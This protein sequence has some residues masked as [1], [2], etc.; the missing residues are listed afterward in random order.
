MN[1]LLLF[2]Y[3]DVFDNWHASH[4]NTKYIFN[5]LNKI[6]EKGIIEPITKN[7]IP[8]T[9][10]II[11]EDNLRESILANG[12]SSRNRG[13]LLVLEKLTINR[14][15][16]STK[17]LLA[18]G[19]SNFS[20]II[21]TNFPLS[22]CGEYLPNEEDKKKFPDIR[23]LD[24][25]NIDFPDEYFDICISQ[26]VLEHVPDLQKALEENYRVLKPDGI[27]LA[28]FPFTFQYEHTVKAILN[29]KGEI[30]H[31]S[32]PEYH[33]YPI[34]GGRLVYTIPGWKIID[35]AKEAGFHDAGLIFVMSTDYGILS[36]VVGGVFIFIAKKRG[37][38]NIF[39]FFQYEL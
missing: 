10:L 6:K 39:D 15:K 38:I 14:D 2:K 33:G 28:T 5:A 13:M 8:P 36:N 17:I 27:M 26:D 1:L 35:D 22:V 30:I 9:N 23:H 18:E 24:I 4:I 11:N 37:R 19:I 29:E 20:K 16:D 12:L 7:I 34:R 25:T 31:L 21:S 32:Q 3:K